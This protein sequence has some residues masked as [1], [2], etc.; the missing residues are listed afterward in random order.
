MVSSPVRRT[1]AS[2]LLLWVSQVVTQAPG[3]KQG[4][5]QEKQHKYQRSTFHGSKLFRAKGGFNLIAD[6]VGG[7][8]FI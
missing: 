4:C 5:P 3:P 1:M 8:R 6:F 2:T 7:G